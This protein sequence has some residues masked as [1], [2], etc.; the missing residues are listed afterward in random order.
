MYMRIRTW[1]HHASMI[2]LALFFL[3]SAVMLI[4]VTAVAHS[5]SKVDLMY[6]KAT[7]TLS[8]TITHTVSDPTSHYIKTVTVM[9][10]NKV[11]QT[12]IYNSQPTSDT[13][14]YTY[15]VDAVPGTELSA[16]AE[17]NYF[18]SDTGSVSVP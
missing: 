10:N 13:F 17:C 14:T 9:S 16:Q 11:V 12:M 7:K 2:I 1:T 18:G 8:V 3:S 6:D 5:P 15:T 4:P